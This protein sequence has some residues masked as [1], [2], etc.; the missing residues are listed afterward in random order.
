MESELKKMLEFEAK[1]RD[2]LDQ[3]ERT[4]DKIRGDAQMKAEELIKRQRFEAEDEAEKIKATL[5]EEAAEE[6]QKMHARTLKSIQEL[7]ARA[8]K[9][10]DEA[11][12][13]IITEIFKS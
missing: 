8:K 1:A 4:A 12:T 10:M 6:A 13:Y 11:G 3:S 7:E 5:I 9:R 2:I